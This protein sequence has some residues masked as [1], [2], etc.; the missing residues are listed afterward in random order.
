[1]QCSSNIDEYCIEGTKVKSVTRGEN[2]HTPTR[3]MQVLS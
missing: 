1:M 2:V 3:I